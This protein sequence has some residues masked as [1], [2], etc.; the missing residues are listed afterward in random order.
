MMATI[1]CRCGAVQIRLARN[2][3][4][5]RL[6]CCCHD[7][8]S[9]LWYVNKHKGAPAPP[10]HQLLDTVWFANDLTVVKGLDKI[11]SYKNHN[12]GDTTRFYCK[13][14]WTC[15]IA[16]H[17]V[18]LA[19]MV[20]TQVVNFTG[21]EG[22]TG[23]DL[24]PL[25]ARHFLKDLTAE[26]RAALPSFSGAAECVYDSAA[27]NFLDSMTEIL[28]KGGTGEMNLQVLAEKVGPPFIPED[29]RERMAEGPPCLG[30]QAKA[31]EGR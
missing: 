2:Q 20:I 1:Q 27:E 15:L 25:Q 14:C 3:A 19:K 4:I 23:A 26:Q 22:L 16:D 17:A 9:A 21:F 7:C 24:I 30:Q 12:E 11:G 5:W 28:A 8:M 6:E 10:E 31:A 18:Y 13:D 29:E